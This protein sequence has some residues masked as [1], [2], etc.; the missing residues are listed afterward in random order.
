MCVQ[1]DDSS[2]NYVIGS[3]EIESIFSHFIKIKNKY[4][5]CV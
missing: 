2:I 5:N 3:K 1:R 4:K